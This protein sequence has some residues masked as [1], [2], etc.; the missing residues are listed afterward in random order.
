M[1]STV[2][3]DKVSEGTAVERFGIGG[4]ALL[5]WTK[6][7]L[8]VVWEQL[9]LLLQVI[10]YTFLS[11]FQMFRFE[12][13]VRITDETGQHIQHMTSAANPSESFLFSSLF[14][15]ENGVMVGG[16]NPLSDFCADVGDTFT[17]KSTAEALLS[18]LRA[19][20]LC[21]GLVD[22]FVSRTAGKEE[23]IFLGHQSTWKMGFP[24]DWNIF[25]SSSDGSSLGEACGNG[26]EKIFQQDITK[27]NHF[28]HDTS[29]EE[30]S[31]STWS[32]EED[33]SI[34]EFDSEE[35]KAL[36]ESLSKSSDPYNPF[37]FSACTST[38][39]GMCKSKSEARDSS[40][41]DVMSVS[42]SSEERL[43]P[44][45]LSN[46]V[47]RSDS[48]ISWS[49]SDGSSPDIDKEENERLWDFFSSPAD[50][51]SPL[52]FTA[53]TI[54][55]ISK[56]TTTTTVSKVQASLPTPSPKPDTDEKEIS[57]PSSSEDDEE[58][59]IWKSLCQHDDPYH[60][61]NFR[62]CLQS[63]PT[64]E[65]QSEKKAPLKV[66]HSKNP[67]MKLKK[68]EKDAD[69]CRKSRPTM[70]PLPERTLKC[71][72]LPDKTL[73][74]WKRPAHKAQS[75]PQESKQSKASRTLKKVQFSPVVQVHVMRTWLFAR[76][77]SRKG[78]WEVM[79]RDRDRFRR[80]VWEAE[81]II[82]H[83][84][85][86]THREKMRAYLDTALERTSPEH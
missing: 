21:C 16:S 27:G 10:Y 57:F 41:T 81:K 15:G 65:S 52:C 40:D 22:D 77:T 20:D 43:G 30:R 62:A 2:A 53:C 45:G 8:T 56:T 47:S 82:G 50:P 63:N 31:W 14:D 6:Q 85:T 86:R 18:S 33:Q 13:H 61:L 66:H 48:E 39:A 34:V 32:S 51:Y 26:A 70:P 55:T 46:L 73:V 12:V 25:V 17:G 44:Q 67:P 69:K 3:T 84:F 36:W 4:M 64:T 68:C 28:K 54:S 19:D 11:V 80:R 59:Q 37:F 79:A 49:S 76:Q 24:G 58:E 71:Q 78:H 83:C 42:K 9:R 75:Q 38:N 1:A 5:P 74:P 35:S 7:I 23:G 72:P 29:E 60:P